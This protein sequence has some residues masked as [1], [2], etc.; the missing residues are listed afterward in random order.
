MAKFKIEWSTDA[1]SDL[2]EILDYYILRNK[3]STYSKKLNIEIDK[4]IQL[5]SKNP[6]LGIKTEYNSIRVININEYQIIYEAFDQLILIIMIWDCR[7]NPLD[8]RVEER[9]K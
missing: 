6:L 3:T 1:K 7:R 2:Y 8:K 9:I 5:V 4:T